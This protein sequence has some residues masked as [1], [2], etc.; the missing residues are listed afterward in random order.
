MDSKCA[1]RSDGQ[2]EGRM[3]ETKEARTKEGT[4]EIR[5]NVELK[6][7]RKDEMKKRRKT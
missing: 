5:N 1:R 3:E 7:G 6:Q 4:T 2:R